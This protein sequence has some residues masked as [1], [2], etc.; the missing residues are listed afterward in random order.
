MS[1]A[2]STFACSEHVAL[3]EFPQEWRNLTGSGI[4]PKPQAIT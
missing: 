3:T 2:A 1:M 4:C